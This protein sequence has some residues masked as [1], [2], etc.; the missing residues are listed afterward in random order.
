MKDRAKRDLRYKEKRFSWG[1]GEGGEPGS[2]STRSP[3]TL[4]E[5]RHDFYLPKI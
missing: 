2:Q 3:L 4:G 5:R 1:S